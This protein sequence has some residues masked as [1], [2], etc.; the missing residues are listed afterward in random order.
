MN[1]NDEKSAE[2]AL[3][4]TLG[5]MLRHIEITTRELDVIHKK[6]RS[7]DDYTPALAQELHRDFL[8]FFDSMEVEVKALMYEL[9]E[10]RID[11]A[12]LRVELKNYSL[13]PDI[14]EVRDEIEFI[15]QR[16]QKLS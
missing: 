13:R 7:S 16:S 1:K 10:K 14:G 5:L 6:L 9:L 12:K 11:P 2:A 4:V 15:L 3:T 8:A